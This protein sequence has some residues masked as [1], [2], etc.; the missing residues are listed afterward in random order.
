MTK[1]KV[2]KAELGELIDVYSESAR[3]QGEATESGDYK[4]GNKTSDLLTV[5]YSELRRRGTDAQRALLPLLK[6][7]D[8]G[9]KLWAASHAMGFSPADGEP[10]LESLIPVGKFLGLSAKTT[11][12]EW[13]KGTLHFP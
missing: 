11:L 5:I 8:P 12:A 13:R 4:A 7:K 2:K 6:A 9:I 10:V 3:I 1:R